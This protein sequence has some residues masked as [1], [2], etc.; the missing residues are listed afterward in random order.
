MSVPKPVVRPATADDIAAFYG[1]DD[2]RP[3][4]LAWAGEV[5]GKVL[6]IGGLAFAQ[7]WWF[8]FCDI[9]AE[10]RRYK[11][12]IAKM[13]RM[14]MAEA[15]ARG[16]RYVYADA[17]ANEPMAVRWLRSLGFDID[18]RSN[19]YYRWKAE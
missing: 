7:G 3:T 1:E 16:I 11:V 2:P 13:A 9:S 5:D 8:G 6:G 4:V 10:G 19:L 17:D 15:Q 12:T 14:I 18:P